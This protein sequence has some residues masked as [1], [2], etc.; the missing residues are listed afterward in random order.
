MK[1]SDHKLI[2]AIIGRIGEIDSICDQEYLQFYNLCLVEANI[3]PTSDLE[4]RK[5]FYNDD[6]IQDKKRVVMSVLVREE[7][8]F[9]LP[10]LQDIFPVF[11][12]LP[13]GYLKRYILDCI[14]I[15]RILPFFDWA[16]EHLNT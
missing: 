7:E 5:G 16:D 3:C 15:N 11:F 12:P 4:I 10:K 2:S 6:F 14:Q 1:N 8:A 13:D 9:K